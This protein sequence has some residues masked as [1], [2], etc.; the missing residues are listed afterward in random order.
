MF[1]ALRD[2]FADH[3]GQ[4][5]SV[6]VFPGNTTAN[7]IDTKFYD[8]DDTGK[9]IHLTTDNLPVNN[10]PA[11]RRLDAKVNTSHLEG[12]GNP[13]TTGMYESYDNSAEIALGIAGLNAMSEESTD[14]TVPAPEIVQFGGGGQF[15]GAGGGSSFTDNT[16]TYES[17]LPAPTHEDY[18]APVETP[19][20]ISSDSSSSS[21][22][23]FGF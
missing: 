17:A 23:S 18:S 4:T 20:Y 3:F 14:A 16:P 13:P 10:V 8:A 21:F 15:S 12:Y 6:P 5:R 22:D 11:R 1:Q 19:S 7:T 9:V 2:F